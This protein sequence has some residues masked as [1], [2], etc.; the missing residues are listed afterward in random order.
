MRKQLNP[1]FRDFDA[2]QQER[3]K[4]PLRVVIF[5][6]EYD[7]PSK[8]PASVMLSVLRMQA[9]GTADDEVPATEIVALSEALIGRANLD[10]M[11]THSDFDLDTLGEM[12]KWIMAI[13]AGQDTTVAGDGE[14]PLAPTTDTL[15]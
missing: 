12:V 13:H 3:K 6:E 14:V 5:G 10:K 8:P 1:R 9:N 2:F 4:D 15:S 11:A 7:L